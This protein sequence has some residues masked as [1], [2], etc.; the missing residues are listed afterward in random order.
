MRDGAEKWSRLRSDGKEFTLNNPELDL[1]LNE[2]LRKR[3]EYRAR[4]EKRQE[5]QMKRA[6]E[7][8]SRYQK[9]RVAR[10]LLKNAKEAAAKKKKDD[11]RDRIRQRIL[12]RIQQEKQSRSTSTR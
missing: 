4:L 8:R 9:L 10:R 5:D 7:R 11:K 2:R 3:Q 12:R 1:P 6:D